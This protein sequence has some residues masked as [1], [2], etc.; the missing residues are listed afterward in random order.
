MA[1]VYSNAL[2]TMAVDDAND[3]RDGFLGPR[4][5]D[6]NLSVKI[7]Y[8][9]P[10]SSI[11]HDTS[12]SASRA[13]G[14]ISYLYARR[15]RW[16]DSVMEYPVAHTAGEDYHG[17]NLLDTRGWTFQERL[18]SPKTLHYTRAEMAF[19][20]KTLSRCEC[21]RIPMRDRPHLFKTL[22]SRP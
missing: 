19:E 4:G 10:A 15:R 21:S 17:Q 20:C 16:N 9:A 13:P 5:S 18:L 8:S 14:K 6:A 2:L 1:T 11:S 12:A 3:S 7:P 22:A